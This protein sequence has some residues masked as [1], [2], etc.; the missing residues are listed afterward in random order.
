MPGLQG[1]GAIEVGTIREMLAFYL[2]DSKSP[3]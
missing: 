2:R 3:R 1:Q